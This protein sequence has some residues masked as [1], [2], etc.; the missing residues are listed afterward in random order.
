MLKAILEE[1]SAKERRETAQK[2][3]EIAVCKS[4]IQNL[5]LTSAQLG[6]AKDAEIL[7]RWRSEDSADVARN[8][9]IVLQ[10]E[11]NMHRQKIDRCTFVDQSWY[12]TECLGTLQNIVSF[13]KY[14][15]TFEQKNTL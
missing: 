9:T 13:A 7:H 14:S 4:Q 10:R 3:K 8:D 15:L 2:D 11:V 5:E 12:L 6:I 1:H